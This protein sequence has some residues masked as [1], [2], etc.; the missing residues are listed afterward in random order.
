MMP[1]GIILYSSTEG[2]IQYQNKAVVDMFKEEFKASQGADFLDQVK[3]NNDSL[4]DEI[5]IKVKKE[6]PSQIH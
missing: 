5:Y 6:D 3:V 2:Q 1:N 4:I